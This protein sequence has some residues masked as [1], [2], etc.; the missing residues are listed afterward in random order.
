[1]VGNGASGLFELASNVETKLTGIHGII[2][3]APPR[4]R[5]T[6]A[7]NNQG[8]QAIVSDD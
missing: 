3:C 1:M 8:T 7:Q 4:Q 5:K 2:K 6:G